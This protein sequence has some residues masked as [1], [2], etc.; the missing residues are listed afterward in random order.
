VVAAE[1]RL[2][3]DEDFLAAIS[4]QNSVRM[5]GRIALRADA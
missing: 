1:D 5:P 3:P 2:P 4:H